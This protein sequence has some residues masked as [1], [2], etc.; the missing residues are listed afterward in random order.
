ML[1]TT[2][3]WQCA[4]PSLQPKISYHPPMVGNLTITHMHTAK[5]KLVA[6]KYVVQS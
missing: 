6:I 2:K 5:L 1:Y 4:C 3:Y